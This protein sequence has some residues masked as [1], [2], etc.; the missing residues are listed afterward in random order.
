MATSTTSNDIILIDTADHRDNIIA[1]V[2]LFFNMYKHTRARAHAHTHTYTRG[3]ERER[4]GERG[5]KEKGGKE[6][7]RGGYEEGR[8]RERETYT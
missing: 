6:G 7:G 8:G 2:F 1:N 3:R 5:G 4:E